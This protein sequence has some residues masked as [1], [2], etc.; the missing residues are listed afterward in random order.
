MKCIE[1]KRKGILIAIALL[2]CITN[3]I[4]AEDYNFWNIQRKGAN[5]FNKIPTEQWFQDANELGLGW[6]RLAYDK[7]DSEQ[8]DFLIGDASNYTGLVEKDLYK[9]KQVISWAQKHDIKLVIAPLGL[10]GSRFSQNNGFK[11]DSRLWESYDY[12]DQAI[13]FWKDLAE[14]LK[15]YDNIV[16]YNIINEPHPELD[17][18]VAEHYKPGDV[19]R[20]YEWYDK[21]QNTPR[22]I[23]KF[24]G[25]IIKE[26]RK[27]E[28]DKSIMVDAG[29]YGQPGA[30]CY[31][32]GTLADN[33]ILYAFHMYEPYNFTSNKN[34][35]EKKDYKYP[36]EVPFGIDKVYWDKNTIDK[37][38][39]PFLAWVEDHGIP[40]NR[41][42]AGEFGCMRKNEG[43]DRYLTDIIN[44]FNGHY[45]Y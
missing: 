2:A 19:S 35:K 34:Y 31:W 27:I 10:P 8:R 41:I 3:N 44:Y 22:D 25:Q 21:M 12:W 45:F 13:Q 14:E 9:L 6:V 30:F 5:C 4:F 24:Y 42:V 18:G 1:I 37:Y 32:P 15:E 29:W 26:I 23:Y 20:F 40:N 11:H 43:A 7:W 36:G 17:T 33:N 28:P 16:A 39:Q 38:F